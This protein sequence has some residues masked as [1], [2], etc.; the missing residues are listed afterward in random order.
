MAKRIEFM[1]LAPPRLCPI[2]H[3]PSSAKASNSPTPQW[4]IDIV[5]DTPLPD[6]ASLSENIGPR[7]RNTPHDV[8]AHFAGPPSRPPDVSP[9]REHM[10]WLDGDV[11]L[12]AC[13]DCGAPMTVRLWLMMA[14]CWRCGTSIELTLQQ[15]R[16]AQRVL[17][18]RTDVERHSPRPAPTV[19]PPSSRSGQATIAPR[20]ES[21]ASAGPVPV[22]VS[23][24]APLTPSSASIPRTSAPAAPPPAPPTPPPAARALV[25]ST[26]SF[27][28][29]VPAWLVSLLFHVILLIL[30]GLLTY[31][32]EPKLAY[33]TLSTRVNRQVRP[34]GDTAIIKPT[35]QAV[36]DLGIPK[37]VD[38][39]DPAQRRALVRADQ[40]AR[41]LRVVDP[42]NPHL[43]DLA[44]T[45]QQLSSSNVHNPLLARDPRLRVEMVRREGGTTL[46]EAAVAR[47][48][49]WLARHQNEDGSWSIDHFQRAGRCHCGNQGSLHSDVTGTA[50][51]LLPFLG[52]GQTH[53]TGVY[54]N[55]VA[56]GLRWLV[57]HQKENGDL[58]GSNAQ[59]PGMYTQGQ[60]AI[61]LCEA[62]LMT[63]DEQLRRPAQTAIDFIV[64]AQY[65]DGG[66]RYFPRSRGG[67]LRGDTS[68]FGWQLMALQSAMAANLRVP[69]TTLENAD[70]FLDG[71][72]HEL[73]A[74]YAYM[75]GEK[76]TPP[77]SAE[78]LL[79][80]VYL[81]WKRNNP[82]LE[83][84]ITWML[85]RHPPT[86]RKPNIY[87]WYYGTQVMH[88]FGG[89]PWKQW[90]LAMRDVLIN[91]Q[92]KRGHRAGSWT[93][94]GP[95][96]SQG[97]RIYMT[98][99]AI[100]CLE[101]YYRHLP[102]F[103]QID[104]ESN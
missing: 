81:G 78:G 96:S 27:F 52:A 46:T 77:M 74:Q 66:W 95:L 14:D 45:K 50:L 32:D 47:G 39:N 99:L 57:Q 67:R 23:T 71:V 76:A 59:Y 9:R 1:S 44:T 24:S 98:S 82:A 61:V 103:R 5:S 28:G 49:L 83:E 60:A 26:G 79:C 40:D 65:P 94:T 104:L 33:I 21:A 12:C 56:A 88:H 64:A 10:F 48:L 36:Y 84:G 41:R 3:A 16:E 93:P 101:V 68:V 72:Q 73:G 17:Q 75:R 35:E 91:S 53:L 42:N 31:E 43:P 87:Y 51:A 63:G 69:E 15:Q 11:L 89:T 20:A 4:I 6:V 55:V 92:E 13:P 70:H 7:V 86:A 2:E 25:R 18:Q 90:N 102:L 37:G 19:P 54:K 8:Q 97:G 38:M 34:G 29:N 58:R 85:E 80:R 62:F 100:C 30:L 22:A